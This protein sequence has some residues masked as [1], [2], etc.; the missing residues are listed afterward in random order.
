M[1]KCG[2][3]GCDN[4]ATHTWSGHPTCDDCRPEKT[5]VTPN[6]KLPCDV[7]AHVSEVKPIFTQAMADNNELPPVGSE[8]RVHKAEYFMVGVSSTGSV[9]GEHPDFMEYKGF[10][11]RNCKPI[12]TEREKDIEKVTGEWPMA[13][14]S[15]IEVMLDMGYQ[16]LK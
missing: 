11:A 16:L 10:H 13:D 1:N 9:V 4:V 15:T 12:K 8:F 2:C 7:N 14:V 3:I 6:P 5:G